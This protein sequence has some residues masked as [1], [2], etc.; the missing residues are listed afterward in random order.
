MKSLRQYIISIF[1]LCALFLLNTSAQD[2][3]K[4]GL[5]EGAKLRIGNGKLREIAYF[6]DGTRF[7]VVTSI[8]IRIYDS[9]TG[10]E[11]YQLTDHTDGIDIIRFSADGKTFATENPE[12]SIQLWNANTG[13]H[14]HTLSVDNFGLY[15]PVFSP[16]GKILAVQCAEKYLYLG[17]T[18]RLYDVQ[19]GKHI[20]TI[21]E[22][23][24]L[25][26]NVLFSPDNK[27]LLTWQFGKVHLWDIETWQQLKTINDP[28]EESH[29]NK[30]KDIQF[31]PDGRMIYVLSSVRI[32]RSWRGSSW[33]GNVGKVFFREVDTEAWKELEKN[34]QELDDEGFSSMYFSP[35]GNKLITEGTSDD[36]IYLWNPNTGEQLNSFVAHKRSRKCNVSYSKNGIMIATGGVD[37]TIRI[38]S[39]NTGLE[40]IKLIG[41][42]GSVN[43]ILFSPDGI[44]LLSK[45]SDRTVRLWNPFSGKLI[46]TLEGYTAGIH[47]ITITPDGNT[48]ASWSYDKTLRLYETST[49][50]LQKQHKLSGI[51]G[52]VNTFHFS[53]TR[54]TFATESNWS[55]VYLWNINTGHLIN[56]L[57]EREHYIEQIFYSPNGKT[58]AG[59]SDDG[60]ILI[61]DAN[62][63]QLLNTISEIEGEY[64]QII[65]STDGSI[66]VSSSWENTQL[67]DPIT[68]QLIRTITGISGDIDGVY[69]SKNLNTIVTSI[70]EESDED[71]SF[72]WDGM[73]GEH[74]RDLSYSGATG[75]VS[76]SPDGKIMAI[77]DGHSSYVSLFDISKRHHLGELVGHVSLES[78][79]GGTIS[80]VR[81]SHNGQTIATASS[82]DATAII[83]NPY[84]GE[85]L[86]TLAGH[87]AGINSVA[88]SPDGTTLASGSSDGTILLWEIE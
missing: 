34:G 27:T 22:P 62:T 29:D 83:W 71:G 23:T 19:T 72:L 86:K 38:Y 9:I 47:D 55:R 12:S 61:W 1:L 42:E 21:S 30:I 40:L 18:L 64:F 81:F 63:G 58:I 66:I 5:P 25:F 56:K 20:N 53:P 60:N 68:G 15:D 77:A 8:G 14:T 3:N 31:S 78:C 16:N 33:V 2:V 85:R 48:I 70:Y 80:D 35:D 88:F 37:G 82:V 51:E 74:I 24:N 52:A 87:T 17:K 65:Y 79:G 44:T 4:F 32:S 84:T 6:P 39:I 26:Y 69:F 13:N 54:N 10:K 49:G 11:L 43:S 41:H 75:P 36:K 73:T 45:G 76:Y 7:A 57:S 50:K 46:K 67:W 28:S 59:K